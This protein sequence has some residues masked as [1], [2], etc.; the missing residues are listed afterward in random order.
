MEQFFDILTIVIVVI[1]VFLLTAIAIHTSVKLVR[2][3]IGKRSVL[4]KKDSAQSNG[5]GKDAASGNHTEVKE[6]LSAIDERCAVYKEKHL[7]CKPLARRAHVCIEKKNVNLIKQLLG[8][9]EPKA[10]ISG[11]INNIVEE[12]LE[13]CKPE[14]IKLYK[15]KRSGHGS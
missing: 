6:K 4:D 3:A 13:K 10:S 9:I 15:E 7:V 8:V 14:I 5:A 2:T 12:H 1:I 11:Y